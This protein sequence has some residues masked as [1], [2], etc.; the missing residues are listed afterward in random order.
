MFKTIHTNN[1]N[2][3]NEIIK[4]LICV[5]LVGTSTLLL[6]I[7]ITIITIDP[8]Q[9]NNDENPIN[10][11]S[12]ALIILYFLYINELIDKQAEIQPIR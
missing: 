4:S 10:S 12:D 11:T 6:K 8:N 5:N 3:N 9:L 2:I 1:H 7:F